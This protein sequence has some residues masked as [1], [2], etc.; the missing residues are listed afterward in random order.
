MALLCVRCGA[1]RGS[2][3]RRG[4]N[5]ARGGRRVFVVVGVQTNGVGFRA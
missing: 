2:L 3:C 4:G 1:A 5:L